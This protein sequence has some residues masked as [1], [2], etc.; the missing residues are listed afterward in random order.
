MTLN[1]ENDR[2]SMPL[3]NLRLT[4][5]GHVS[6]QD[7]HQPIHGDQFYFGGLHSDKSHLKILNQAIANRQQLLSKNSRPT[8]SAAVNKT[9]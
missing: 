8:R 3:H 9:L 2:S 1:D 4:S 7:L 5:M 6:S